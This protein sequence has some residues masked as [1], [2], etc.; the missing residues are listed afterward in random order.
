MR[1]TIMSEE[2][3]RRFN[4]REKFLARKKGCSNEQPFLIPE[5]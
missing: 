4:R 1:S 5:T 2:T 3:A